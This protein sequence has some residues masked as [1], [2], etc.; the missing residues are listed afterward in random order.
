[1]NP[2]QLDDLERTIATLEDQPKLAQ[3]DI[4]AFIDTWQPRI[5]PPDNEQEP[6][7]ICDA[8][9][10]VTGMTA[11]RWLC[12]LLGLRHR[13]T[14]IILQSPQDHLVLQVRSANK[15]DWPNL[16]DPSVGGHV[17]AGES[18]YEAALTEMEQELGLPS[19]QLSDFLCDGNLKQVGPAYE[20][21]D[22]RTGNPPMRN[23]QFNQIFAGKLTSA[24]L[25]QIQ[26]SDGEVSALY[27]CH[28]TEAARLV[29]EKSQVAPGLTHTLPIYLAWLQTAHSNSNVTA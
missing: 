8:T 12:H 27:I 19:S 11:P 21:A 3:S 2:A 4:S 26:F 9:G 20:R 13:A 18:F 17:R 1:M 23:R 25:S 5:K 6:F 22:S 10:Q 15:A 28:A 24:G 16:I 29:Q 14:H 7:D